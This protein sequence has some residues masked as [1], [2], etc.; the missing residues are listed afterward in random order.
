M[1]TRKPEPTPT[2]PPKPVR[3]TRAQRTAILKAL[4]DPKRFEL[5]ET[6]ARSQCPLGCTAA[7]EALSIAPATL[8]HHIKELQTS[9]LIDV[10]REGKFAFLSIKP[11]VLEALSTYLQS[12]SPAGCPTR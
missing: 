2:E 10:R 6:I 11:G 1:P 12:L 4:S 9:G 7:H 8:S 3:L 5:L